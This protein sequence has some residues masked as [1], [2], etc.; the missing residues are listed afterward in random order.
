MRNFCQ[1]RWKGNYI[2]KWFCTSRSFLNN[3]NHPVLCI[4]M[5]NENV[6]KT[7]ILFL[8]FYNFANNSLISSVKPRCKPSQN[9]SS[10]VFHSRFHHLEFKVNPISG[11]WMFETFKVDMSSIWFRIRSLRIVVLFCENFKCTAHIDKVVKKGKQYLG[12]SV[13]ALYLPIP[14]G[15]S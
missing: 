10:L 3:Y 7:Y 4:N 2:L 6:S 11:Y 1:K 8:Q 9:V 5:I 14:R 12:L 13:E 15:F